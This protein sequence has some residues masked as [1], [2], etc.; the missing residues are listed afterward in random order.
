MLSSH[1]LVPRG[2]HLMGWASWAAVIRML[3]PCRGRNAAT[4]PAEKEA[5]PSLKDHE[6][7]RC[8]LFQTDADDSTVFPSRFPDRVDQLRRSIGDDDLAL[9]EIIGDQPASSK[10]VDRS[11]DENCE[12]YVDGLIT[13][14]RETATARSQEGGILSPSGSSTLTGEA[15]KT[16]G[17]DPD[18]ELQVRFT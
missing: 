10:A 11:V 18:F 5:C 7:F 8:R 13:P 15:A 1:G 17:A 2:V 4:T 12:S 14:S 16:L 3:T 9:H 6:E